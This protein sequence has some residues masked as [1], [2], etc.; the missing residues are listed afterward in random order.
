LSQIDRNYVAVIGIICITAI[1]VASLVT[2]HDSTIII[3]LVGLVGTI[4]GYVFGVIPR[5]LSRK[6]DASQ[7][8]SGGGPVP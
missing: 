1:A 7:P 6:E 2:N 3:A 4:L 5:V 8:A